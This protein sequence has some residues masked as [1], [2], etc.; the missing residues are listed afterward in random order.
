MGKEK[1]PACRTSKINGHCGHLLFQYHPVMQDCLHLHN[2]ISHVLCQD[3][4]TSC[5]PTLSTAVLLCCSHLLGKKGQQGTP[6]HCW[7]KG[8][9]K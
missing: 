8:S 3:T 9:V 1:T 6:S 4:P 2:L 5:N 7:N